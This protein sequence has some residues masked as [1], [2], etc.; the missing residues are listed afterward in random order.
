[1]K[2]MVYSLVLS[3]EVIREVD[4]LAYSLNTNR[5]N[6]INQILAEYVSYITPE[7]RVSHLLSEI[8]ERFSA[9]GAFQ[10]PATTSGTMLSM[11]SALA[12]K[13]N[14]TVRYSLE[15]SRGA[16]PE[17]GTLRVSLRT[18]NSAL[19]GEM[20]R[21]YHLW[22]EL[23]LREIGKQQAQIEAEKYSRALVL[24]SPLGSSEIALGSEELG[25]MISDYIRTFDAAL[26]LYFYHLGTPEDIVSGIRQLYEDYRMQQRV[27]I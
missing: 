10:V 4:K 14:P 22:N 2:K 12:Y 7:K 25:T 9:L 5:S 16:L 8:R 13:Y 11:R 19:I 24:Q 20:L 6:M 17:I 15:L 3:E 21:F 23:E 1:M 27:V 26:K 18:Q